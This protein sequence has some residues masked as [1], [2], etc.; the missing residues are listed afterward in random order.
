MLEY[1]VK[2]A[3][4]YNFIAFTQWP[5]NIDETINLCIYGKDY[6]GGEID[7][8]QSRV[9]NKRHIKIVRVNNLKELARC[10]VIF[11]SK[12]INNHLSTILSDLQNK[13]ILTLADNPHAFSEGIVI[14]M[15]LSNEKI[16]FEINLGAAR[17][18]GLDISSKLL[19]LAVKVHQ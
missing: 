10:Q 7:K 12:S 2:A 18:S 8:L 14:N 4:I 13:P 5:D 16:V 19:Q 1:Q 15:N 6:F 9:V 11:F 17:K 3:F